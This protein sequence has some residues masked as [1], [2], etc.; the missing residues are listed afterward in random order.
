MGA[1]Q[2]IGHYGVDLISE[3]GSTAVYAPVSGTVVA[4]Q[5]STG[6]FVL[7]NVRDRYGST[8]AGLEVQ[9]T[10]A[11]PAGNDIP[12]LVTGGQRLG[13]YG[14][15]G[16]DIPHLHLTLKVYSGGNSYSGDRVFYDPVPSLP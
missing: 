9:I 8:L 2:G 13:D 14:S 6:T 7:H 4:Y 10:H 15:I 3:S 16:T 1:G 12:A 11:K 5:V